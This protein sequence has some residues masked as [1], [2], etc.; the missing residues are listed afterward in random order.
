MSYTVK[1]LMRLIFP[2]A[3]VLSAGLALAEELD[4]PV[5]SGSQWM[6]SSVEEKLAY[7]NGMATMIELEKEA[8]GKAKPAA[9][10]TGLIDGWIAG[11]AGLRLDEIVDKLD[12]YYRKHPD[13]AD[14]PVVETLWHEVAVPNMAKRR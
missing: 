2:W 5:V 7:V 6:H 11:L 3:L 1:W 10:S 13:R 8:Q 4:F 14:R 12:A 9:E